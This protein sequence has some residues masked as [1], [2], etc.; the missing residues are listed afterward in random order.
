M[1]RAEAP[2]KYRFTVDDYCRMHEAGI[3]MEDD[4]LELWDG[5][6]IVM[7]AVGIP[8]VFCVTTQSRMFDRQLGDRGIVFVQQPVLLLPITMPEPDIVIARPP[9]E[10]YRTN[11]ITPEDVLLIIEVA[12]SS[13]VF[14]RDTKVP[15]Y[16]REGMPEAWVWDLT[17]KRVLAYSDPGPEGY[18]TMRIFGPGEVLSP[19]IFPDV[20][21]PVDE[22]L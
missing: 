16:G 22:A 9:M 15:R 2:T 12:D 1:T 10:A 14:D 19:L 18:S 20:R 21:I 17:S 7:S 8:H 4:P 3:F 6:V 5:D 13:L 11:R